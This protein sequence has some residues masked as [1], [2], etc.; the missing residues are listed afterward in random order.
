VVQIFDKA[1]MDAVTPVVLPAL[2]AAQRA[3][4]PLGPAYLRQVACL[5]A[6]AWPFFG[7]LAWLAGPA[8]RLLLGP[9]W[10][11]V[12]PI[13]RWLSIAGLFLPLSALVLPYLWRW[14]GCGAGCPCRPGCSSAAWR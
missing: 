10:D 1:L 9:D 4:R 3:G 6:V 11:A 7:A 5:A 12:A 8:V 13:V 14:S 2:S